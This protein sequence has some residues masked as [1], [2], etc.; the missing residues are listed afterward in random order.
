M[1]LQKTNIHHEKHENHKGIII[2]IPVYYPVF[3]V[4]FMVR[5]VFT[6]SIRM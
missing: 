6:N 4:S 5:A 1:V 3:F 2:I